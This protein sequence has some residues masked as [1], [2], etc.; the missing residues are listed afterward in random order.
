MFYPWLV[1]ESTA[2]RTPQEET[3]G[4]LAH[5]ALPSR[6]TAMDAIWLFNKRSRVRSLPIG[7]PY[8]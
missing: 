3:G 5:N 4:V 1:D 2:T 6:D 7:F 8:F